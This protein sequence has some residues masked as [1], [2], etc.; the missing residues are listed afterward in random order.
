MQLAAQC[1]RQKA[2]A[3]M[4]ESN[5]TK[6]DRQSKRE[7]LVAKQEKEIIELISK[8]TSVPNSELAKLKLQVKKEHK[9]QLADFDKK[10]RE[11]LADIETRVRPDMD[12]QHSEKVL[13]LRERQIKEIASAMQEM[14]PEEALVRSY[15]EEAERAAREAEQYRKD[16]IEAKDKKLAALK[17]ERMKREAIRR[18]EYE[19]QLHELEAEVEREKQKDI[20]RQKQLKE[21]YDLIQKQRLAEQEDLH[22]NALKGMNGITEQ[23]RQVCVLELLLSLLCER[24]TTYYYV[25][26]E[27]NR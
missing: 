26:A 4:E 8:S 21:R 24:L 9:K 25:H 17:E 14:S 23:E 16:V 1:E 18:H 12:I 6:A 27:N 2:I 10:T 7:E 5:T 22:E 11:V 20:E 13:A 3:V 15:Q 19:Q